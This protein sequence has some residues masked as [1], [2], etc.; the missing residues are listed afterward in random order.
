MDFY[1]DDSHV[2]TLESRLSLGQLLLEQRVELAWFMRQRDSRRAQQLA[3]EAATALPPG[4]P[5]HARLD[6]L[7]AEVAG[8]LAEFERATQL[9]AQSKSAFEA[10]HDALGVGDSYMLSALLAALRGDNRGN[11]AAAGLAAQAYGLT[12]DLER[13]RIAAA[14]AAQASVYAAPDS[15]LRRLAEARALAPW[16]SAPVATLL[17]LAEALRQFDTGEQM[18]AAAQLMTLATQAGQAGMVHMRIRIGLSLAAA[19]SNV[20][21]NDNAYAWTDQ[22]LALARRAG[23]PLAIG[24][25]LALLGSLA[26]ETG[27][28]DRSLLLLKEAVEWLGI[29]PESRGNVLAHAYLSHSELDAGHAEQALLTAQRAEQLGRPVGAWAGVIDAMT[30]AARAQAMLGEVDTARSLAQEALLLAEQ[31]E[32]PM[33]QPDIYRA[34]AEIH[35]NHP[36]PNE[37]QLPMTYLERALELTAKQGNDKEQLEIL[38]A[39]SSACERAG[40]YARALRYERRAR[41][42][43]AVTEQRRLS[44][45]MA[46]LEMRYRGEQQREEAQHQRMLAEAE[47]ARAQELSTSLQVLENLGRIGREITVNLDLSSVLQTLVAHLGKLARVSYVG[48]SVLDAQGRLLIRRGVED[49]RPMPE[50][51]VSLDDPNSKAAQCARER[52]EILL[53]YAAGQRAASHIPGTR[54][55]HAS[56]FGPLLVGEDL[57]GVLTIQSAEEH[58]YGA[59][60][61]LIFR[62]LSAYVGVAVS[63]A[64]VYA[65]LGEQHARLAEAEA[66]MRKLATTDALTGIPNRRHF[67]AALDAEARRSQRSQ[68]PMAVVMADIDYFKAINDTLGHAAGDAVLVHVSQ[69]LDENKRTIDTVGRLGG[70]EFAILLPE[71]DVDGAAEVADRLRRLIQGDATLWQNQ[72]IAVSMSFGCA[73][74]PAQLPPEA[75]DQAATELLQAADRALYQAKN[76]GR[77]LTALLRDGQ[78]E[79]YSAAE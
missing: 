40:D 58:A 33:W 10:A 75:T 45:R 76:A 19:L 34:L 66:E 22:A 6:L 36:R 25:A 5:L 23:W 49:G 29:A 7:R 16:P 78:G 79:L 72:P 9:L 37:Q 77:N 1:A 51:R 47:A 50:R 39:L 30:V 12:E 68:R 64:R 28:L 14:W 18:Q 69:L 56:W 73:A 60:E 20:D 11:L 15:T 17:G 74:L 32:L 46:A 2:A 35:C 62:T 53:E 42:R 4:H 61:Q 52:R 31:H 13:S 43:L 67:L 26:R 63:N 59:R 3:D 71:T 54:E 55:M 70:E 27:Q 21:D 57:V 44:N 38:D 8:L 24:D 48:L 65:R 41:E